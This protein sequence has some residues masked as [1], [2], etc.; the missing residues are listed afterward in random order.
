MFRFFTTVLTLIA[1][2]MIGS[3]M[4]RAD[5]FDA[6]L[7]R[8]IELIKKQ[9]MS[10]IRLAHLDAMDAPG[11]E[12]A[13]RARARSAEVTRK[14]CAAID[15]V[16]AERRAYHARRAGGVMTPRSSVKPVIMPQAPRAATPAPR[17]RQGNGYWVLKGKVW[18][19]EPM[20]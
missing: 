16:E 12:S 18:V 6:L 9:V 19:Y 15:A 2:N 20:R 4:V 17:V 10:E 13:M 7:D 11:F 8:K 5:D 1:L 14:G 3:P